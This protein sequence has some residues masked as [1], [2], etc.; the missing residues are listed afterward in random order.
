MTLPALKDG[1]SSFCKVWILCESIPSTH[2]TTL[3]PNALKGGVWT[4]LR[5][6]AEVGIELK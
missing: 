5:I 3:G 6:N 1:V 4:L 2:K